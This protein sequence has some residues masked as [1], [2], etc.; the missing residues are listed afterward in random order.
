MADSFPDPLSVPSLGIVEIDRAVELL[1][2]AG[3]AEEA[4][5]LFLVG[6][7]TRG[8][9]AAELAGFARVLLG[10]AVTPLFDRGGGRPLLELC[11]TGGGQGR[12]SEYLD[13]R[14]VRRRRGRGQGG[15]AREQGFQFQVR[16]CRCA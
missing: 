11:G 1:L 2:S 9:T 4:K 12:L 14:D 16:Q 15:E 6:L 7:H 8:E 5:E 3:V 10:R 13:R